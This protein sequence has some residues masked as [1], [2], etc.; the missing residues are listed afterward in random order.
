MAHTSTPEIGAEEARTYLCLD[1]GGTKLAA[2]IVDATSGRVLAVATRRTPA[3]EGAEAS[4]GLALE[5]CDD[6]LARG[7]VQ[8]DALLGIG[9][10]FGGPVA[11]GGDAV[12]RSMHVRSWEGAELPERLSKRFGLPA[13]MENDANAAA[14]AE[15]HHGAGV[16]ASSLLYVQA[17]TG[18]GAGVVIDGRVFRGRGG[19]GELGHVVVDPDGALCGC[20]KRGCLESVAAGWAIA[21]DANQALTGSTRASELRGLA[22]TRAAAL[23]AEAVIEAARRSDKLAR[24]LIA[25]AFAALGVAVANSINLLDPDVIVLGGGMIRAS[26]LLLPAIES[27]LAEHVVPHLRDPSR[28]VLSHLGPDAPLVG[29]AVAADDRLR[30]GD[31][32]LS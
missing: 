1:F 5:A 27:E 17:S 12:I 29:A 6:V 23:D 24:E 22:N 3:E 21:R 10:S 14:L 32:R 15:A 28:L 31:V 11:S 25:R 18:V 13:V 19:A 8:V 4:V 7:P 26:D 16:G 2:G 9:I 30:S 20:G